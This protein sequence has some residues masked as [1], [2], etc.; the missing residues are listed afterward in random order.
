[1]S[2]DPESGDP[3]VYAYHKERNPDGAFFFGVPLRSLTRAEYERL[4][5]HLQASVAASSFYRRTKALPAPVPT[6][7]EEAS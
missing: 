1:M 2:D 4:P 6:P 5:A 3:I 7:T